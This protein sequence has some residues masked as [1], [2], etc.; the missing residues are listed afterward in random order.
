LGNFVLDRFVTGVNQL[1]Q[2]LLLL[3]EELV[4]VLSKLGCYLSVDVSVVKCGRRYRRVG[5]D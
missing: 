1:F 4:F 5:F 3:K 2:V